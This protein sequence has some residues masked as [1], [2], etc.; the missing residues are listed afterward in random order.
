MGW[1][2]HVLFKLIIPLGITHTKRRIIKASKKGIVIYI[3]P[4]S[5]ILKCYNNELWHSPKLIEYINDSKYFSITLDHTRCILCG[6]S[7][8][9]FTTNK[10]SGNW[11]WSADLDH[12]MSE[13]NF[14]FPEEF[15]SEIEGNNYKKSTKKDTIINKGF[16][17]AFFFGKIEL[18]KEFIL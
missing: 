16:A 14:I 7:I 10:T 5:F 3:I 12:Y 4:D 15:T 2:S 17:N 8:D 11:I 6:K 13:H 9:H 18:L 1:R